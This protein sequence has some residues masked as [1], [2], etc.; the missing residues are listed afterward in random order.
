MQRV[1]LIYNPVSG[2][3]TARRAAALQQV[4]DLVRSAGV[5]VT[6]YET[7]TPGSATELARQAVAQ[8]CDTVLACGGDGTIHAVLQGLAGTPVA[9]GVIPLG[10]ANVLAANL[11]LNGSPAKNVQALLDAAPTPVPMARIHY[12]DLDGSPGSR[13][14]I[15]AAGIGSDAVVM[16]R[17]DA[18]LK[19]RLG[20]ILYVLEAFRIWAT[21]SFPL[22]KAVFT[23]LDGSAP[24]SVPIS[25]LLAIRVRSLGGVLHEFAPGAT[26]HNGNLCLMA[27]RTQSRL[28][29]LRFFMAVVFKRQRFSRE[30]ELWNTT[31]IDCSALGDAAAPIYVEAD[32][33]LLGTLPVRIETTAEKL[34]LL[35]PPQAQP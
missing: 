34:V 10:T 19:R 17:M 9:M 26:L 25:Q 15:V 32:G 28:R 4:Q 6:A 33:E 11:G 20:Y 7:T 18:N 24:R 22:F 29:Y 1:T 16:A 3:L 12:R 30:V 8:G 21:S 31:A 5:D 2:Q 14:F 27:F 13:Y 35:V 23:P